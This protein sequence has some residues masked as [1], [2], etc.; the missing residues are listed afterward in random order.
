MWLTAGKLFMKN[1]SIMACANNIA[2][3][4]FLGG[5]CMGIIIGLCAMFIFMV[6]LTR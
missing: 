4:A 6:F 5:L 2:R 3:D 1:N